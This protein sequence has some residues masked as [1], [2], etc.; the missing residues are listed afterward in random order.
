M[1]LH[2]N[3]VY[4]AMNGD[5]ALKQ[6]YREIYRLWR[7]Q[8]REAL[9]ILLPDSPHREALVHLIIAAIDGLNVQCMLETDEIPTAQMAALLVEGA[10]VPP[11]APVDAGG[12]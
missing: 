11:A 2:L 3:L 4:Q 7:R 9:G 10:R 6:R 5:Q 8:A 12:S 1:R